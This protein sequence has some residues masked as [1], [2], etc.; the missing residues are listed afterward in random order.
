MSTFPKQLVVGMRARSLFVMLL[1]LSTAVATA[2]T[3][4]TASA[5]S[6]GPVRHGVSASV[7][8]KGTWLSTGSMTLGRREPVMARTRGGR[9][10]AASGVAPDGSCTS[11]AEIY[12][13]RTGTWTATTPL[14]RARTGAMAIR[15]DSGRVLVAGG[16][17]CVSKVLR[18]VEIYHPATKQWV[19]AAAMNRRRSEAT[20]LKLHGG[21]VMVIGGTRAVEIYRPGADRWKLTDPLPEP[22]SAYMGVLGARLKNGDVLVAGGWNTRTGSPLA[23]AVR[24]DDKTKTWYPAGRLSKRRATNLFTLPNGRVLAIG[25]FPGAKASDRVDM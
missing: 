12:H 2:S 16:V 10:L 15:L 18:S 17:D 13:P 6:A 1:A 24:Y 14:H 7:V 22:R 5:G 25:G 9:V 11:S 21:R 23:S 3:A 4:V 19:K 8:H 20:L